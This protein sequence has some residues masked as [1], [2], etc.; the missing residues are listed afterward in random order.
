MC[1]RTQAEELVRCGPGRD[2]LAWVDLGRDRFTLDGQPLTAQ[3]AV[4]LM[5]NKP[6]GMVTTAQDE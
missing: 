6:R 4:Y 3:R 1:S 2:P 5:L